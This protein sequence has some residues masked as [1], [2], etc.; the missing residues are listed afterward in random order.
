MGEGGPKVKFRDNIAALKTIQRLRETGAAPTFEDRKTLVRYVGWGGLPQAFDLEHP[1]WR[2]EAEELRQLLE[3]HDYAQARRSTQDAHYT[4]QEVILSIYQGLERLGFQGPAN[5]LEP[6]A[7]IGHFR[8]LMPETLRAFPQSFMAVEL[9]PLTAAIGA[10]LYPDASFINRGFQEVII[11]QGYFDLALGN[12]PFGSQKIYDPKYPDYSIHNYFLAK[13]VDGLR[14]GGLA[15]FVVSRYFLDAM[16]NPAREF[17]AQRA[18]FLGAVRLPNTAFKKNALTE[19]T[20]DIVF[21]H[22]TEQPE[23][24][25]AWLRTGEFLD[26][27]GQAINVNQYYLDN[28]GQMIGRMAVTNSMFRGTADLLPPPDLTD[29]Q[30]E[31]VKRLEVLP[32][33]IYQPRTELVIAEAKPDPNLELCAPLK[34]DAFFVTSEGGLAQRRANLLNQPRYE[35]FEPKNKK[36]GERIKGLVRIRSSLADLMASELRE[37]TTAEELARKRARLNREY[38]LFVRQNGYA[39]E[40]AAKAIEEQTARFEPVLKTL[41]DHNALLTVEVKRLKEEQERLKTDNA[42][43][44]QENARFKAEAKKMRDLPLDVVLTKMFGATETQDSRAKA[45]RFELPDGTIIGFTENQWQEESQIGKSKGAVNLVMHLSGYGQEHY[46]QAV[47]DM[48]EILGDQETTSSLAQY[49]AESAKRELLSMKRGQFQKPPAS[50]NNWPVVRGYLLGQ[51]RLPAAMI[52]QRKCVEAKRF[53]VT[54]GWS[55][56]AASSQGPADMNTARQGA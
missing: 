27:D 49:L 33:K 25:P 51:M 3:P 10:A 48:A 23:K 26:D 2:E 11:P 46:Q 39:R 32:Q 19:V 4:S 13:S 17:I 52:D 16:N 38:D 7:G 18:N 20:T 55:Q 8:G 1:E 31:I 50:K 54:R 12:P 37:E 43:L 40:T 15:A 44:S 47:R 14:P 6:S 45:R 28:P 29:I 42:Q 41:T 24:N 5:I 22:R 34:I 30:A 53:I 35:I 56:N 9:E 36:A 21:F